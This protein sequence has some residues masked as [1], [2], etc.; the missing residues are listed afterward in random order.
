MNDDNDEYIWW[1]Y[2]DK[3]PKYRRK[4]DSC[5]FVSDFWLIILWFSKINLKKMTPT[6]LREK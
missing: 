5:V 3:L 6:T 1:F 4:N 2:D